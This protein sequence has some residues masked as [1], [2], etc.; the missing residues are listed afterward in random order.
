MDLFGYKRPD[1]RVG[2]RNRVI[3]IPLTGCQMEVGR[4][5]AVSV[6]GATCLGHPNGCD[7]VGQDFE[8]LGT[9]LEHIATHRVHHVA[10]ARAGRGEKLGFHC[11]WG[12]GLP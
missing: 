6:P 9:I 3:V 8:L 10:T 12:P 4:R 2:F 11:L 7:F 1:G 5:I